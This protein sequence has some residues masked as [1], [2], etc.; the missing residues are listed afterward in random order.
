MADG[1]LRVA[2]LARAGAA[3]EQL[4]QALVEHGAVLVAEGD[5][6]ELD[7]GHVAAQAPQ[8]L[9]VGLEP[10]VEDA[11]ERFDALVDDA[12]IEVVYDD[13]EVTGGLSGWER[14]R[15]VRHLVAKLRRDDEVLPPPPEGAEPLP[16]GD[17]YVDL[18]PTGTLV[19]AEASATPDEVD[20]QPASEADA[21]P[22]SFAATTAMDA[23]PVAA[24]DAGNPAQAPSWQ[25]EDAGAAESDGLAEDAGAMRID[26]GFVTE[27]DTA[28]DGAQGLGEL[29]EE[30]RALLASFDAAAD[31]DAPAD[32]EADAIEFEFAGLGEDE[33]DAGDG[34]TPYH[35]L[36]V[37][38]PQDEP[39][40]QPLREQTPPAPGPEPE[41]AATTTAASATPTD[42][43][44]DRAGFG[45]L[46]LAPLDDD[47]APPV[48]APAA[49]RAAATPGR[50]WRE[51]DISGL[52]LVEDEPADAEA[53]AAGGEAQD[54]AAPTAADR[55]AE[56]EAAGNGSPARAI[57]LL[58]GL[59]GPDAVRQFLGA[60]PDRLRVPVLL[61]QKLDGARHDRLVAQ[62]GRASVLPVYLAQEGQTARAGQVAVLPETVTAVDEGDGVVRFVAGAPDMQALVRVA[63]GVSVL[64]SGADLAAVEP[65]V[66]S[67]AIGG[68]ALAQDPG[69]C[70]D[71]AA[72]TAL[73]AR[74]GT[75]GAPAALAALAVA[76]FA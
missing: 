62:L 23:I 75:A 24:D 53:P 31:E 10:A 55:A 9:L 51:I 22:Q 65:A 52:S 70:F 67:V 74:G 19:G 49:P 69:T 15:W 21:R 44:S 32:D 18:I 37:A 3:R 16:G 46:S 17:S 47:A 33:G 34:A 57:L 11:L 28:G 38:D 20:A 40:Y 60:L 71:A 56:D 13:V 2:L 43:A 12:A 45:S 35:D 26:I 61:W 5:P 50:D 48:T 8:V 59:G 66:L 27:D 36:D 14:A 58:A 1:G 68:L 6:A 63:G 4:R 39:R 25:M 76:H 54:V 73:A 64:L 29:S 42:L 41:T 72:A 7:P 30:D